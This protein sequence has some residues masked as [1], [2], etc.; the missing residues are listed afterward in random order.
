MYYPV[1]PIRT[2]HHVPR[3][4]HISDLTK[5]FDSE[6]LIKSGLNRSSYIQGT[7]FIT[8]VCITLFLLWVIA[9]I[10][11]KCCLKRRV[12][13]MA[14]FPPLDEREHEGYG[15]GTSTGNLAQGP[16]RNDKDAM[17]TS[18]YGYDEPQAPPPRSNRFVPKSTIVIAICS[19]FIAAAGTTFLIRGA[20]A[21]SNLLDD[22]E[23]GSEGIDALLDQIAS[24]ADKAYVFGQDTLEFSNELVETI[25]IGICFAPD[26]SGF[27]D[28]SDEINEQSQQVVQIIED[29]GD[30]A[31]GDLQDVRDAIQDTFDGFGE[32]LAEGTRRARKYTKPIVRAIAW[33][34][35]GIGD[36]K[37]VV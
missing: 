11:C 33:P 12:G 21:A 19:L 32:G 5:L 20:Y 36:R 3:F 35:I 29:L 15:T 26:G 30:Y 1:G 14:G 9:L 24:T 2:F 13:I 34:I 8:G 23:E 10:V 25:G 31:A 18:G 16:G 22:F 4:G 7:C 27:E 6:G 28:R 17:N 37:S